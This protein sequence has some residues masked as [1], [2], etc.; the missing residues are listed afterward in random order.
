MATSW[1]HYGNREHLPADAGRWTRISVLPHDFS[2]PSTSSFL[3]FFF[4]CRTVDDLNREKWNTAHAHIRKWINKSGR[5]Q[6]SHLRDH[7]TAVWVTSLNLQSQVNLIIFQNSTTQ[8][9]I[10][11]YVRLNNNPRSNLSCYIS[12]SLSNVFKNFSQHNQLTEKL[13]LKSDFLPL[14]TKDPNLFT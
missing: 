3:S 12:S 7:L 10:C 4:S 1:N 11:S 14:Q 9:I 5:K 6:L 8:S 2:S 13:F